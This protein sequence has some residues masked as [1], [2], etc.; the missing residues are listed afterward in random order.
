M[1]K[2]KSISEAFSMQPYGINV[3]SQ[4]E[5]ENRLKVES[6]ANIDNGI[7]KSM[8]KEMRFETYQVD[9]DKQVDFVVGYNFDG[10]K[11]FEYIRASVNIYYF[12][13]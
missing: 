11:L 9:T 5:Y 12:T 2:I 6:N 1:E 7:S 8:I 10:E 4:Q 13:K 3:S